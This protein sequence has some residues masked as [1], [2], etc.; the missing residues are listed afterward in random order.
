LASILTGIRS[1]EVGKG[2]GLGLSLCYGLIRE[3]GGN[4]AVTS[5]VGHGAAFNIELPA[6]ADSAPA[7][8]PPP[9]NPE[10]PNPKE[11][12]GKKILLVDDEEILLEMIRDG[13]NRH[14]YEVITA[15]SGEAALRELHNLKIDAICTDVKMPGLNGRQLYDWIR[16]SRPE[17]ARRVI[18]MT[19]DVINEPL[20]LFLE[21]E[22]LTCLNK[23]F[24]TSDLRQA[25]KNILMENNWLK[26]ASPTSDHNASPWQWD[27]R[28]AGR[29]S[30]RRR[31]TVALSNHPFERVLQ[32]MMHGDLPVG[33]RSNRVRPCGCAHV[34]NIK[35]F[36]G[37]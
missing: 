5:E 3:H 34:P 37:S 9:A 6:T 26:M 30:L 33:L 12:A 27:Q 31:G 24:T 20:R 29:K 23:P 7:D 32:T 36:N 10:A 18:F 19:A 8:I 1:K 4:I 15:T 21:Q 17:A 25:I 14:G 16:N 35:Q 22:Q 28:L 2:T 13:L 11:G